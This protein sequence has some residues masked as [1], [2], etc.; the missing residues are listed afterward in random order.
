MKKPVARVKVRSEPVL[1]LTDER[2]DARKVASVGK[3]RGES[4]TRRCGT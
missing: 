1:L 2:V 3:R 4:S